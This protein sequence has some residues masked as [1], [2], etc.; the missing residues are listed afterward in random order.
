VNDVKGR[1]RILP[2]IP[3]GTSLPART[4]RRLTVDKNRESMTL[5]LVESSGVKSDDWQSLGRY[6]FQIGDSDNRTRMIGFEINVNGMLS[7]RAQAPGTPA[8]TKLAALPTPI[9]SEMEIA[10]WTQWLDRLR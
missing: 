10:E 5:S 7:V 4:N 8:S 1:R 3:K 2:I 6:E 9:L